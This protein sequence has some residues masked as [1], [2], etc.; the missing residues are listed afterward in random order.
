MCPGCPVADSH[1]TLCLQNWKAAPVGRAPGRGKSV[2]AT[3]PVMEQVGSCFGLGGVWTGKQVRYGGRR[4]G[5]GC[6]VVETS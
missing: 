6:W 4:H 2:P 5:G 3:A 1:K